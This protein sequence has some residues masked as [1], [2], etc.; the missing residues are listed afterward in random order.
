MGPLGYTEENSGGARDRAVPQLAGGHSLATS[1]P[2]VSCLLGEGQTRRLRGPRS[3]CGGSGP[4]SWPCGTLAPCGRFGRTVGLSRRAEPAVYLREERPASLGPSGRPRSD[5]GRHSPSASWRTAHSCRWPG[6]TGP[7]A[8]GILIAALMGALPALAG[9]AQLRGVGVDE[10]VASRA[11]EC[12]KVGG[13]SP[14]RKSL[15]SPNPGQP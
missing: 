3:Q 5:P 6:L 14:S 9:E 13:S 1:P 8:F 12:A 11:G 15:S 4:S 7:T 10:A 2:W